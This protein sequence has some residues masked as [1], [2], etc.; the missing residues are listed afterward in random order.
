MMDGYTAAPVESDDNDTLPSCDVQIKRNARYE[1]VPFSS[2]Q[3][4]SCLPSCLMPLLSV[5]C[6]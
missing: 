6:Y 4:G 5:L 2:T 3:E 1:K